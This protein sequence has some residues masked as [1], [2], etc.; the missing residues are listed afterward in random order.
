MGGAGVTMGGIITV[1]LGR[2]V[3]FGGI[4]G[5]VVGA[6]V[7][8]GVSTV[9]SGVAVAVILV[10]AGGR[11]VAGGGLAQ[12]NNRNTTHNIQKDNSRF[13]VGTPLQDRDG[14]LRQTPI[15]CVCL[16]RG[17]EMPRPIVGTR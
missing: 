10:I 12:A 2:K 15:P 6:G 4:G 7:S 8:V 14:D 16:V 11:G 17:H 13:M 9:G 1:I 3:G 5:R